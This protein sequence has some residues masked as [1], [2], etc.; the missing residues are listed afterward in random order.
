MTL[1]K[2][3]GE[4]ANPQSQA[5]Q[6]C[7][8]PHLLGARIQYSNPALN[9]PSMAFPATRKDILGAAAA[10]LIR[11]FEDDSQWLITLTH[12]PVDI[13]IEV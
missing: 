6:G 12:A 7:G 4:E 11:S 2:K 13:I 8:G 9:P 10:R 5:D 3:T 1:P